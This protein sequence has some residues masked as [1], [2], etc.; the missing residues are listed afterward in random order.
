MNSW[1]R[2][3]WDVMAGRVSKQE[4]GRESLGAFG[5]RRDRQQCR[6]VLV[7]SVKLIPGGSLENQVRLVPDMDKSTKETHFLEKDCEF[8]CGQLLLKKPRA[9]LEETHASHV[10]HWYFREKTRAPWHVFIPS[11]TGELSQFENNEVPWVT[12]WLENRKVMLD[13]RRK[14]YSKSLL[15]SFY[16]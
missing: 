5:G 4:E 14:L 9:M 13:W 6:R 7:S 15:L 8:K 16:T 12:C 3:W 10:T 11:H 2:I 1:W